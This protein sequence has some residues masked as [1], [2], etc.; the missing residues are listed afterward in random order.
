ML[1]CSLEAPRRGASNEHHNIR[2]R[3]EIKKKSN[4]FFLVEKR[5]LSG[6][7]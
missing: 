3:G 6:A 5:A 2:F 4:F 7:M 1:W